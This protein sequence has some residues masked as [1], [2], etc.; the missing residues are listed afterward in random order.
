[1]SAAARPEEKA[2]DVSPPG[3]AP[4]PGRTREVVW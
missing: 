4:N 1:L 2:I 3:I